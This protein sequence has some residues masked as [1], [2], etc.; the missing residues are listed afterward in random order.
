[1][2]VEQGGQVIGAQPQPDVVGI[3]MAL[4]RHIAAR[5][6]EGGAVGGEGQMHE[7]DELGV[8]L[9]AENAGSHDGAVGQT[10][11]EHDD[12]AGPLVE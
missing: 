7:G 9:L 6:D 5:K 10:D 8:E 4:E 11:L 2:G 12:R 1:M 3:S